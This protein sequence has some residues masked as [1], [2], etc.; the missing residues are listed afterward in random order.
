MFKKTLLALTLT[1]FFLFQP[2]TIL[3]DDQDPPEEKQE[4]P[5][6]QQVWNWF[7]GLVG[8]NS[9]QSEM[10]EGK[11]YISKDAELPLEDDINTATD[12]S[13]SN[14]DYTFRTLSDPVQK[15][16]KG[17][18]FYEVVVEK[19]YQDKTIY[20]GKN[21]DCPN[22]IK[23]SDIVYYFYTKG[24]KILYSP[25]SSE[26]IDYDDTV[27][28]KYNINLDSLGN[29]YETAYEKI[30]GV[31]KGIFYSVENSEATLISLQYNEIIRNILSEN[32]QGEEPPENNDNQETAEK[33]IE[34]SNKQE[35]NMNLSLISEENK[36]QIICNSG[37]DSKEGIRNTYFQSLTPQS[38]QKSPANTENTS[39][40][41]GQ[42]SSSNS[43][44]EHG[45]GLS[46]Y[47]AQGMALSGFDYQEILYAYYGN[48]LLN[49]AIG[50]IDGT[51]N[52]ITVALIETESDNPC[53]KLAEKYPDLIS[54]QKDTY[55]TIQKRIC[56]NLTNEDQDTLVF[57]TLVLD[58]DTYLKGL[59]ENEILDNWELEAHKA[60]TI[61]ART[62]AYS[63][64]ENLSKPI[65]N[66]NYNQDQVF[67]CQRLLNNLENSNNQT[68]AVDQTNNEVLTKDGQI[69]LT[70]YANYHGKSSLTPPYFDGTDYERLAG[71]PL[72]ANNDGICVTSSLTGYANAII[73]DG[74]YRFDG[75]V[76]KDRIA[77]DYDIGTIDGGKW[78]QTYRGTCKLD[79]RV[80]PALDLLV[81]SFES[82][83]PDNQVGFAWA[84]CYRTIEY[85][86]I[87][88][89]RN[90]V[91]YGS[92][93]E[94]ARHT[95]RPGTSP[96]HTGRAIDFADKGGRLD[97][98]SQLYQWLLING[99][100]FGFYNYKLEPWH[101]EYNP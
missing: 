63:I 46:Q 34:D 25:T 77:E 32:N 99:I 19:K 43:H 16:F 96:H 54:Y 91:K 30:T 4:T 76:H 27:M 60:L 69:F 89:E 68:L 50:S 40:T 78:L 33:L 75:T 73:I 3:A 21:S 12:Y 47:G 70:E 67:R 42:S 37:A 88:W 26:P 87:L 53:Q 98:K 22:K 94:A 62:Y 97:E 86:T 52:K 100:R 93:E 2:I 17:L 61:A 81:Q 15:K 55:R 59:N 79:K 10:E 5:W 24:E 92:E 48:S 72:Y 80:F 35:K 44:S 65:K 82:Q 9:L 71:A 101:W 1:L 7:T 95:A 11:Y 66:C 23:I 49:I 20:D 41:L 57:D 13:N 45:R 38:W 39:S 85:Q 31:P 83:Y 90:K 56:N 36:N 29:C 8:I 28:S 58:M 84:G 18:W 14:M 6:P 51:N 64:T 74:L